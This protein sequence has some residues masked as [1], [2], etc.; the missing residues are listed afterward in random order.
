MFECETDNG[1]PGW[2]VNGTLLQDLSPEVR[3]DFVIL[4][5]NTDIGSTV[6]QLMI[7]GRAEYNGTK[8]Q[9]LSVG[10][11][12]S[13]ESEIV[14]LEIQGIVLKLECKML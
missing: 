8:I 3:R 11:G 12:I 7:P 6:E 13:A 1:F 9:C 10:F 4:E 14:S 5:T 2:K